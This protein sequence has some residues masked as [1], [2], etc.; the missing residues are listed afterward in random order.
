MFFLEKPVAGLIKTLLLSSIAVD[1]SFFL[2]FFSNV[3]CFEFVE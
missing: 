2:F 1:A 3:K